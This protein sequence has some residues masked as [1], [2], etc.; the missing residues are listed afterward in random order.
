MS[1]QYHRYIRDPILGK[2]QAKD[3]K[4]GKDIIG[5]MTQTIHS[6]L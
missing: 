1:E 6:I 4:F 3:L 5:R 2:I